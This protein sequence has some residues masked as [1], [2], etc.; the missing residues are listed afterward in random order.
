MKKLI[1]SGT[2]YPITIK[3]LQYL[4]DNTLSVVSAIGK[5]K[6]NY[7]VIWGMTVNE[8]GT[9]I[10]DGAFVYNGEIIPFVGGPM[11]ENPTI[12]INE[13]I[14]NDGFN[15]NPSSSTAVET[16][17]A[18]SRKVGTIGTG[19]IHTASITVLKRYKQQ[20]VI[21]SGVKIFDDVAPDLG[22][23]KGGLRIDHKELT[24]EE[25]DNSMILYEVTR[26]NIRTS[27]MVGAKYWT[28]YRFA[29]WFM[30]AVEIPLLGDERPKVFWQIVK[31]R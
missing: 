2:G 17:P 29:S 30:M 18:Y 9:Q 5:S 13:I 3:T 23:Y 15:T 12:T 24:P 19:G 25:L 21:D 10:T 31:F 1:F 26:S 20:V 22:V 27:I 6:E 16:L 7:E 14:D 11:G 4:Q 8:A 28:M